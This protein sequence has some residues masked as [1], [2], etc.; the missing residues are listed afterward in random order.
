MVLFVSIISSELAALPKDDRAL[1]AVIVELNVAA[2]PTVTVL[3]PLPIVTT[4]A[5]PAA[6]VRPLVP[7]T[8]APA[9]FDNM[10][11]FPLA[12]KVATPVL[13]TDQG[14]EL[15]LI[16]LPVPTLLILTT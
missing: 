6:K 2:T 12:A 3:L 1:V 13:L 8:F 16:S 5:P 10:I 14:P 4:L 11:A 15:P 7:L 9:A